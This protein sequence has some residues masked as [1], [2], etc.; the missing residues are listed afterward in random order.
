MGPETKKDK[1][2]HYS[3]YNSGPGS[4]KSLKGTKKGPLFSRKGTKKGP[5]F[6]KKGTSLNLK[7]E[8]N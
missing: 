8:N 3:V 6:V 2:N 1:R 4:K 7:R 5:H